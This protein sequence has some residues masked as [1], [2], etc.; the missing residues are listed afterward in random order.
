MGVLLSSNAHEVVLISEHC[1]DSYRQR[2]EVKVR[3][4]KLPQ[5]LAEPGILP[6]LFTAP[7]RAQTLHAAGS[8]WQGTLKRHRGATAIVLIGLA[9]SAGAML[10]LASKGADS[11]TRVAQEITRLLAG[12]PQSDRTLGYPNAPV[13]LEVF[14]DLKDPDSRKWWYL[15]AIIQQDVRTGLLQL[16]FHSYKTNTRSPG[17]F[18]DEQTA[19]LA[20]G[21]QDK[22]WNSGSS[23]VKYK[24]QHPFSYITASDLKKAIRELTPTG[25]R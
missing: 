3:R 22:L 13:T 17:E 19:A 9:V 8:S 23:V 15:P 24:Q 7:R 14:A 6:T 4:N 25:L 1:A 16:R 10:G 2:R 5:R 11:Q 12:I 20:A 21:A 18:V